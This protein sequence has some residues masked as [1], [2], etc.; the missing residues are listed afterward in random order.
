[1][2]LGRNRR[3]G[4]GAGENPDL[5]LGGRQAAEQGPEH[6]LM[7]PDL[8]IAALITRAAAMMITTSLVKPLNACLAGTRPEP[9]PITRATSATMSLR[10]RPEAKATMAPPISAKARSCWVVIASP[11]PRTTHEAADRRP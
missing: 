10:K 5:R 1:N 2:V 9:K 8:P 6:R 4:G 7:N 11:S 3:Q